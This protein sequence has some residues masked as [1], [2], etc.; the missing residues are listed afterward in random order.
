MMSRKR[1]LLTGAGIIALLAAGWGIANRGQAVDTVLVSKGVISRTVSETGYVRSLNEYNLEAQQSGQITSLA[2][3]AGQEVKQGQQ[4][5]VIENPDIKAAKNQSR[6][7]LVLAQTESTLARQSLSSYRIDLEAA[8]T[9]YE[10][11]K[12]LFEAGAVSQADFEQ[13]RSSQEKASQLVQQQERYLAQ[14]EEKIAAYSDILRENE[15][16][17]ADLLINSPTDGTVLDLPVKQGTVITPGAL[18][19][20]IGTPELLEIQVDLL[21]DQ[22]RDVQVGQPVFVSSPVLGSATLAGKIKEIRP[23]AYVKISALGVEQRR[24]PVI[25]TLNDPGLLKPGYEVQ[26]VIQTAHREGV[27]M[28]SRESVRNLGE[29]G[30]QVMKVKDKRIQHQKIEPGIK[31]QDYI[32]VVQGLQEGDVIVKDGSAQLPEKT[33]VKPNK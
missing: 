12:V 11:Q 2:V 3:K 9:H 14:L 25:I 20:Q 10:R 32:E 7:Q 27:L 30:Y 28:V 18:L 33:T 31:N 4:L 17:E 8:Q 29:A 26:V 1:W 24:V 6:A 15:G 13:A 5:M 22:M 19:C 23:R 21:G 16:K